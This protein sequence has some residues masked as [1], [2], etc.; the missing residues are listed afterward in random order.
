MQDRV[1]MSLMYY[2]IQ[3]QDP[4]T[5]KPLVLFNY[6]IFFLTRRAEIETQ[7]ISFVDKYF[8]ELSYKPLVISEKKI[9]SICLILDSEAMNAKILNYDTCHTLDL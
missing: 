4:I 6:Q 3:S 7:K 1:F 9:I 2:K 5:R 8:N